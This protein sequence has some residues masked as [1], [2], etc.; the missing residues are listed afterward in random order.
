MKAS[1]HRPGYAFPFGSLG[2]FVRALSI[3]ELFFIFKW[4][5]VVDLDLDIQPDCLAAP[6][7]YDHIV[8][9][10]SQIHLFRAIE[11]V[12]L[13]SNSMRRIQLASTIFPPDWTP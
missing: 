6:A 11:T 9:A 4:S 12:S 3:V 10:F 8:V 13:Q 2:P 7:L 1:Y 5:F